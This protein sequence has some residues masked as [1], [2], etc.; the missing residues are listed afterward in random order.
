K[1]LVSCRERTRQFAYKTTQNDK[2]VFTVIHSLNFYQP[3]F[4]T[5]TGRISSLL[6]VSQQGTIC[7]SAVELSSVDFSENRFFE[8]LHLIPLILIL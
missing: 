8:L 7:M 1:S 4:L 5:F 3:G 2:T 6:I